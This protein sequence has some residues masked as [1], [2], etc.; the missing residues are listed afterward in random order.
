MARVTLKDVAKQAGVSFKTVSRVINHEPNVA[1]KTYE[2]VNQA[3]T[4]LH[5]VP[6]LAA[7]SLSRGKAKAIGLVTGWPINTPYTSTLI[8]QCFEESTQNGYGMVLFSIREGIARKIAEAY[9]GKQVDG[10]ILDTNAAENEEL[11]NQLNALNIPYVIIHPNRINGFSNAS[12]VRINNIEAAKQATEYLIKLGHRAIGYITYHF[13]LTQEEERLQG[14]YQALEEAGIP[15]CNDWVIARA[16]PV[17]ELGYSGAKQLIHNHPE[18]TAIF[19]ETDDIAMG[20]I[21]AIWQMGLKVPDDISVI[22][23][24]DISYAT[25]ITPPLTT[26]HQPIDEIA[27]TAVKHL[28]NLIENPGTGQIDLV[29]ATKL[30]VRDTCKAP[31]LEPVLITA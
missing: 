27:R 23:F 28:I 24:D 9:L 4:E 1:F 26:I 14:Y 17:F 10:I 2:K 31:R 20:V 3:I 12:Y 21:S 18:L 19:T 7:R 29:M 11:M 15:P 22:G 30:V 13:G 8:E 16:S 25:M 6:N 5:Y